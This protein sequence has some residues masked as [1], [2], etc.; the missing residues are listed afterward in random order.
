MSSMSPAEAFAGCT[1][2]DCKYVTRTHVERMRNLERTKKGR[3]KKGAKFV[4]SCH[5]CRLDREL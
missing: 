2:E 3:K 4:C 5:P 1:C